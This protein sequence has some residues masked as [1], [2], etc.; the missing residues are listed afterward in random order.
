MYDPTLGRFLQRDPV[1]YA[2]SELDLYAYVYDSPAVMIDPLGL[3][4][5]FSRSGINDPNSSIQNDVIR[6]IN[7]RVNP[8]VS[9]GGHV[10]S[11]LTSG[12]IGARAA[13]PFFGGQGVS[14]R[15]QLN[16][17]AQNGAQQFCQGDFCRGGQKKTKIGVVMVAPKLQIQRIQALQRNPHNCCDIQFLTFFS[18]SDAVPNQAAGDNPNWPSVG[19]AYDIRLGG[20]LSHSWNPNRQGGVGAAG[21]PLHP[22]NDLR[23]T[24]PL[25]QFAAALV[26]PAGYVAQQLARFG[27]LPPQIGA[28]LAGAT[29]NLA[30]PTNF[31]Q[32]INQVL[33]ADKDYGYVCHSQGCNI[34]IFE[35]TRR[36]LGFPQGG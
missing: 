20:L 32:A 29:A 11:S 22:Q 9:Y 19:A 6:Y 18:S 26:G 31:S 25:W 27:L 34:T 5:I 4:V 3:I 8:S 1:G 28:A 23:G 30:A 21:S 12:G 2:A 10:G 24:Q 35:L 16:E 7:G 15:Q 13:P 17:E 14:A 36:C 33:G